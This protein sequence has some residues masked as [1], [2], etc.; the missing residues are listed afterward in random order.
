M[1][2]TTGQHVI[3]PGTQENPIIYEGPNENISFFKRFRKDPNTKI[4]MFFVPFL[5]NKDKKRDLVA[6]LT[7]DPVV[8]DTIRNH[9]FAETFEEPPYLIANA[10]AHEFGH[11]LSTPLPPPATAVVVDLYNLPGAATLYPKRL[12]FNLQ[13]SAH[14]LTVPEALECRRY[15]RLH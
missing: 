12:M 7:P 11:L 15:P 6:G 10:C 3:L 4:S 13:Q 1:D 2:P 8:G 14:I 5:L 9:F